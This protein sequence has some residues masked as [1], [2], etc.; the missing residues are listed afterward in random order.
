MSVIMTLRAQGDPDKLE[1]L[2][3]EKQDVLQA[4]A[5]RAKAAGVIAHRFYGAEGQIMVIDEWPDPESFTRFYE[6]EQAAIGPLMAQVA[7]SEPEITFWHKLD[8]H[9]DV[10]WE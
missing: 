3:N 8:T 2:A 7:T 5:E 6:S 1:Q 9:D 4:I 10:G